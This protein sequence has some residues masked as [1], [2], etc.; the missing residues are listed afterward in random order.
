LDENTVDRRFLEVML[1]NHPTVAIS[2][3]LGFL[4]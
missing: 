3:L 4:E 2:S 1:H